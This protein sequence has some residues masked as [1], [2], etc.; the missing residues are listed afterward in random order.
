VVLVAGLEVVRLPA[1][2]LIGPMASA[3]V[4]AVAGGRLAV[5]PQ[6]FLL[7]Q[8]LLGCMVARSIPLSTLEAVFADWPISL[9]VVCSVM[10]AS[11]GL[12]W[13]LART[14][15]LPGAT[16]VWGTVPG[17]ASVTMLMAEASGADS[18]LVA[19]M[20]YL[21][22]VVVAALAAAV[23]RFVGVQAPA[24]DLAETWFPAVDMTWLAATLGV[25][26]AGAAIGSRL[27]IP[28]GGL[29]LPMAAGVLLQDLGVLRIELPPALL[30]VSYALI[31]WSIGLRF[32]RPILMHAARLLPRILG[33][34]VV[35]IAV[36]GLLALALSAIADV[37]LL[38][39]YLATSPGG[40]DTVAI[41]AASTN[42]DLPFVM[43][44]QTSRFLC[45]LL[46]GPSLARL[47]ATRFE[48]RPN[49][50]DG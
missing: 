14:R 46:L 37:D 27:R 33:A 4:I 35:L 12:G 18:R 30:A 29:M 5:P 41:I 40:L 19:V 25:A 31:G 8:A 11:T 26:L 45:V 24:R 23:A 48:P 3:I 42:I 13:T 1:A 15:V 9:A 28:A 38:T 22:L 6:P 44:M 16:A 10:A 17:A 49:A 39:A 21:R 34:I 43:A 50:G 36:C 20:Q 7:A 32:T 2:L 47:V